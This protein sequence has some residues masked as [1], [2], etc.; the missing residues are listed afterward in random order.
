MVSLSK[1][2]VEISGSGPDLVLLHGWGLHGGI[3]NPIL[4]QLNQHF[5]VHNIDLPGFGH[6]RIGSDSRYPM[7]AL[8]TSI[9][10]IIPQNAYLMGWSIG[11]LIATAIALSQQAS[12]AKLITVASSPRFT[13]SSDWSLGVQTEVLDSFIHELSKDY[14]Q[15]L[16]NFLSLQTMGSMTAKKDVSDL[17]QAVFARG[18]PSPI[19]LQGGLELLKNTDLRKSLKQIEIPFLRIYG[20]RDTLVP[21]EIAHQVSE[22]VP[23]SE[24][25]IFEKSGH[26]PFISEKSL[27]ISQLI[28]FL[29]Q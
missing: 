17:K 8:V 2:H 6:S 18:V 7:Q 28:N 20:K 13:F 15:S 3:W 23:S 14:Q 25:L 11:G 24:L 26:T 9:S 1:P 22:L 27:F 29:N 21:V 5:R 10:A 12:I 16:T 19:A 4:D